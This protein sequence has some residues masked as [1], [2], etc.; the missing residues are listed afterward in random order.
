MMNTDIKQKPIKAFI[1]ESI[2]LTMFLSEKIIL[3]KNPKDKVVGKELFEKYLLWCESRKCIPY[4][5]NR[6]Y[7]NV[8]KVGNIASEISAKSRRNYFEIKIIE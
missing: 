7:L 8:E 1:P 4:T 5:R 2:G 3:T 6:F